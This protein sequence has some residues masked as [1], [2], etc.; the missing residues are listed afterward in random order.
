MNGLS[1][2]GRNIGVAAALTSV[3]MFLV[4]LMLWML[5]VSPSEAAAQLFLGSMGSTGAWVATLRH[6]VPIC[7]LATGISLAARGGLWN[8]GAEG[9]WI[10][11][12]LAGWL[13]AS[14]CGHWSLALLAGGLGGG[15][16]VAIPTLLAVRRNVS[17]VLTTLMFNFLMLEVLR[18]SIAGPLQEPTGQFPQTAPIP[19][20]AH[21]PLWHFTAARGA[22]LSLLIAVLCA[23]LVQLFLFRTRQG[24]LIRA[25]QSAPRAVTTGG[26]SPEKA[27]FIALLLSGGLCGLAGSIQVCGDTLL[28]DRSIASG[29]GYTAIAAALLAGK[30]P[31]WCIPSAFLFAVLYTASASLQWARDLP[32]MDR[33][34]LLV[35]GLLVLAILAALAARRRPAVH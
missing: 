29:L 3:V 20:G 11:G 16:V 24:L 26:F 21:L 30:Q 34:A 15:L 17:E 13:A 5:G 9:Q 22:P 7:L 31:L 23:V 10:A 8:I 6:F 33:F 35:Q 27:R 32:A 12:A 19:P 4:L 2:H 1:G 14:A 25:T 28:V 18:Y